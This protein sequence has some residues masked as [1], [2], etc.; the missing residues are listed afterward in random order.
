M[1]KQESKK[2]SANG[3]QSLL[4]ITVFA[5]VLVLGVA[6][7][8]VVNTVSTKGLRITELQQRVAVLQEENGKIDLKIAELQ[9]LDYL[10]QQIAEVPY[11]KVADIEYITTAI[12]VAAR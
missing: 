11:E 3:M 2:P 12:S 5:G 9:S 4:T 7:I 6:Y 8:V 1:R 10:E